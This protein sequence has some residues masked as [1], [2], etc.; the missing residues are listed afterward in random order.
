ME[1]KDGTTK[2]FKRSDKVIYIP[3]HLLATPNHKDMMKEE[4]IVTITS[5]NDIFV[6]VRYVD[7]SLSK[8][9]NPE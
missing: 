7:N 2:P 5:K 4:N 6:F 3:K 8:A 1:Q 9:T